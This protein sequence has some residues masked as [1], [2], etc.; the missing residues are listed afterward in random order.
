MS[1]KWTG[2]VLI[3]AGCGGFG[4]SLA[5]AY[6]REVHIL[7]QLA[8]VLRLLY[9]ELEYRLTSLPELCALACKECN[10]TLR[11]VFQDLKREL[12][13]QSSPDAESCMREALKKN[14][15]LSPKVGALLRQLGNCLGRYDLS[16]QLQGLDSV[17]AECDSALN[18]LEKNRKEKVR[19]Y[20]TLGLC[21]GAALAIV[22]A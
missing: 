9:W 15:A 7:R 12:E 2:A 17:R 8:R 5:A 14:N 10:G 13:W 3:L 1:L 4:F 21:A 6:R 20:Q 19:S 16:G 11:N 22:F 18:D